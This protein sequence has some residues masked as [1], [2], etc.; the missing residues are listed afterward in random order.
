M[1][2]LFYP[3]ARPLTSDGPFE[4][5]LSY[6]NWRCEASANRYYFAAVRYRHSFDFRSEQVFDCVVIWLWSITTSLKMT[7]VRVVARIKS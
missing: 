5:S 1:M 2:V 4:A 3:R 6:S 7:E